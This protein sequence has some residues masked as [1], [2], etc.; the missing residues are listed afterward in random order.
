HA[1]QVDEVPEENRLTLQQ[2]EAVAAETTTLSD[3]HTFG[4][5]L[6]NLDLGL[7]VVRGVEERRRVAVRRARERLRPGED[8]ATG[9]DARLRNDE[10]LPHR[11]VERQHLVLLRLLHKEDL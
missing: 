4:A 2:I 1:L 3:Q 11:R 7:E 5:A 9:G 10:A 6:R 8:V